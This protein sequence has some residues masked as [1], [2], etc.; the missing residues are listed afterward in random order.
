MPYSQQSSLET[1]RTYPVR[2]ARASMLFFTRYQEGAQIYPYVICPYFTIRDITHHDDPES[3][4]H[5]LA[6]QTHPL[7]TRGGGHVLEHD[8]YTRCQQRGGNTHSIRQS[9]HKPAG[10]GEGRG[11]LVPVAPNDQTAKPK[12]ESCTHNFR[13]ACRPS[14]VE[15]RGVL[16]PVA[17]IAAPGCDH[18]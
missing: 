3:R 1:E 12:P 18:A 13:P 4:G 2:N 16:L 5:V 14:L 6:K 9:Q 15:A 17:P 11:G 7:N 8:A 10:R